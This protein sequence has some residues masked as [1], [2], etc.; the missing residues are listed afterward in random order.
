MWTIFKVFIEFV[1]ILLLFYVLDFW[2]R[3]MWD[4]ITP[5]RDWTHTP[6]IGRLSLNHWT[7]R[8]VPIGPFYMQGHLLFLK[9]QEQQKQEIFVCTATLF[10]FA[11][12]LCFLKCWPLELRNSFNGLIKIN[13][14]NCRHLCYARDVKFIRI[15]MKKRLNFQKDTFQDWKQ[16]SQSTQRKIHFKMKELNNFGK[17]I[18]HPPIA[19][20]LVYWYPLHGPWKSLGFFF[21][22]VVSDSALLVPT[23]KAEPISCRYWN[24][25]TLLGWLFPCQAL[26]EAAISQ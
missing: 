2:Q 5:T 18:R 4:L 7:A 11:D 3:G 8:E 6:C 14:S 20:V 12:V 19:T 9:Q 25:W 21:A 23:S 17:R 24:R 13:G 22:G 1:T 15:I 26:S 16:N 10:S